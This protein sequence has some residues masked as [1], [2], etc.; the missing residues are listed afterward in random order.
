MVGFSNELIEYK[1]QT[2][3]M[4]LN[5]KNYK[6]YTLLEEPHDKSKF[7]NKLIIGN[8]LGFFSNIKLQLT[9]DERLFANVN[10]QEKTTKFKGNDMI[11]FSG[12][13]VV[14][15]FLQDFIGLGKSVSRGFGTV[16][17]KQ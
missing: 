11:A 15:A 8:V 13:F 5:Q 12:N 1:F 9:P 2:L 3:W 14:N 7:L 6:E 17:R 10:V 4:G 16:I